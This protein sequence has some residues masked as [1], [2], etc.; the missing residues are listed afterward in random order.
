MKRI[1]TLLA[2]LTISVSIYAQAQ[3]TTKKE[4]LS[5]FP[6]KTMKVVLSG[7]HFIDPLLRDAVNNTWSI[8]PFEFCTMKEFNELK[9]SEDYYFMMPVKVKYKSETVPGTMMLTV[10][11]GKAGAENINDLLEVV[12]IPI[13]AADIPSGREAAM[14][15]GIVDIIQG[16]I[17]KSLQTMFKGIGSYTRKLGNLAKTDVVIAE[18][19]IAP[20]V[21]SSFIAKLEKKGIDITEDERADSLF[22]SGNAKALVSYMIAPGD[23]QKG[24]Y[25]WKMLIDART[26]ELYYYRRHKITSPDNAGFLKSDLHNFMRAK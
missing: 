24:S 5:D 3:I 7:N 10:A 17:T 11:K 9:T 8:S 16:Y 21:D 15:P 12:S 25:C 22:L 18:G 23:P 13:C 2:F 4:K 26:H 6:V 1:L 14:L 20:S 19:D